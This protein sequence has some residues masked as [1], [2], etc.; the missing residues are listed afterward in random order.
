M[1]QLLKMFSMRLPLFK[2]I[3]EFQNQFSNI[4]P[5]LSSQTIKLFPSLLF[6]QVLIEILNY[7]CMNFFNNIHEFL[8][9]QFYRTLKT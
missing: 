5:D 4:F 1:K 3:Q 8:V 7:F 9:E 6:D 2:E